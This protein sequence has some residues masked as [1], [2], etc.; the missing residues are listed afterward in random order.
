M[1]YG[2][3]KELQCERCDRPRTEHR[4]SEMLSTE[5]LG[6]AVDA[7]INKLR[8]R[9]DD[10]CMVGAMQVTFEQG[11]QSLH[12]VALSGATSVDAHVISQ[13]KKSVRGDWEPAH[14]SVPA[15]ARDG[16]T[17]IYGEKLQVPMPTP[18]SGSIGAPCAA[19]QLLMALGRHPMAKRLEYK[20]S[21]IGLYESVY[22]PPL[23]LQ[24]AA[25]KR[26]ENEDARDR[27]EA[28]RIQFRKWHGSDPDDS[29]VAHSCE[30]CNTRIPLLLCDGDHLRL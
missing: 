1:K 15:G 25:L 12:M 13:V 11:G 5:E 8:E 24:E 19:I 29:Y 9:H 6:A 27:R 16:W 23:A 7:A 30:P 22:K 10:Y 4:I 3:N 21:K 14:V 2:G 17:D 20:Y 18:A 28:K 26:T